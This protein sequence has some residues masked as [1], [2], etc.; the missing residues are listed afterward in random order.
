M[1]TTFVT[2]CA[3]LLVSVASAAPTINPSDM[4]A[5]ELKKIASERQKKSLREHEAAKA[6]AAEKREK[7]NKEAKDLTAENDANM[8]R[9]IQRRHLNSMLPPCDREPEAPR[10]PGKYR[11]RY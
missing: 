7:E 11:V 1:K 4:S 3:A 2:F 10:D 8:K 5:D 9:S 6:R